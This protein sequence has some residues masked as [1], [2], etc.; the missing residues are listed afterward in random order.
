MTFSLAAH[1]AASELVELFVNQWVQLV[2]CGLIP[3]APLGE[4][5]SDFMLR[6]FMRQ[7]GEQL[8][9]CFKLGDFTWFSKHLVYFSNV[10]FFF[11]DHSSRVIFKQH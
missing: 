9:R 6:R 4:Q 5:L 10:E 8:C 2:E 1:V 11:R 3:V 7:L